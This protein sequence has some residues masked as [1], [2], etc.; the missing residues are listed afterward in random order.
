[1]LRSSERTGAMLRTVKRS[2]MVGAM[3][4]PACLGAFGSDLHRGQAS[5][6]AG[7]KL[8][9][10]VHAGCPVNSQASNVKQRS[11]ALRA[12]LQD[13]YE[14]KKT[15]A[16][17]TLVS[18]LDRGRCELA[19]PG[20]KGKKRDLPDIYEDARKS[21]MFVGCVGLCDNKECKA[22]HLITATGFMIA[23]SGVMITAY[24]VVTKENTVAVG[25]M[26]FEGN[27]YPVREVLAADVGHDVAILQLDGKGFIP[28]PLG[29]AE[30]RIGS[31]IAV[32]HN[33]YDGYCVLS[34]GVISQYPILTGN[35]A[36]N[37]GMDVQMMGVTAEFGGGS[38]GAPVLDERGEVVGMASPARGAS[39]PGGGAQMVYWYCP[40]AAAIMNLMMPPARR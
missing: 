24:H 4:F 11:D 23:E 15:V 9:V 14:Q 37:P 20:A 18:Q 13:L 10:T 26:E 38:S 29:T 2:A 27:V 35:L 21:V 12:R 32:I 6:D 34:T 8:P 36:Q 39:P 33:P 25:A 28:L 7:L 19:L 5:E 31:S 3:C 22:L 30:A 1:M 16:I 17:S 40:P